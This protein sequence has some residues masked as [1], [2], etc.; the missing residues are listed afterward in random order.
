MLIVSESYRRK[1]QLQ[2]V[3]AYKSPTLTPIIMHGWIA[4]ITVATNQAFPWNCADVYGNA[5]V[6]KYGISA[7]RRLNLVY[8]T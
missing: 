7:N 8:S 6:K 2:I 5:E 1:R 4:W 3:A